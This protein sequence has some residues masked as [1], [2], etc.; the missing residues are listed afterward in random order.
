MCS[1]VIAVRQSFSRF[2]KTDFLSFPN[3]SIAE[4]ERWAIMRHGGERRRSE[5]SMFLEQFV[6]PPM[7]RRLCHAWA[8]VT[9][10]ARQA[11]FVISCADAWVAATA[12]R[13][14]IPLLTHN[15]NDFRGVASLTLL[16]ADT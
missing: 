8:Q 3:M 6:V 4:L 1:S 11:G 15:P 7:D 16:T 12:V 10:E 2:L 13:Y 9:E 14:N 5:L